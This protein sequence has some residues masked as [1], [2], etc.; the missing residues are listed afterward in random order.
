[1]DFADRILMFLERLVNTVKGRVCPWVDPLPVQAISCSRTASWSGN[2]EPPHPAGLVV[3]ALIPPLCALVV[4]LGE[5]NA[6][7]VALTVL[8]AGNLSSIAAM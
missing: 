4:M 8:A 5:V 1:M 6:L 2:G 7:S 3:Q